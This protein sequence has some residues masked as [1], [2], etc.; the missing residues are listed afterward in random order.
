MEGAELDAMFTR[1]KL[2]AETKLG[3]VNDDELLAIVRDGE[4]VSDPAW[5]LESVQVVCGTMGLPTAT[6]KMIA[7]D[8]TAHISCVVGTGPVDAVFKA[9]DA[10]VRL[11]VVL[12]EYRVTAV[13]AGINALAETTV[14]IK[15]KE[16][17]EQKVGTSVFKTNLQTGE[18]GLR[19]FTA[20][21][22]DTDIVVSSARAYVIAL[23][24]M[25]EYV[26]K[27]GTYVDAE[28]VSR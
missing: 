27:S 10:L 6:V 25:V 1:F 4:S 15:P 3:G 20:T 7:K 2:V 28:V 23:N 17:T 9:I 5:A 14:A 12:T 19:T 11:E 8:G 21:G 13:T 24:R 22:A 26:A 16:G 18:K